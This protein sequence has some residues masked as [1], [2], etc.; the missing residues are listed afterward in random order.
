MGDDSILTTIKQMLGLEEDY[1]A[2]DTDIIVSINS[3]IFNLHQ[4]GVANSDNYSIKDAS[5]TW[6]ELFDE[7]TNYESIIQYI[8]LKVRTV[9][10][11]SSSSSVQSAYNNQIAELEWRLCLEAD[12][13]EE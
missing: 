12:D 13:L 8:Y 6:S 3:A 4:L 11:P 9:F 10:D 1:D 5:N 2:F 7:N